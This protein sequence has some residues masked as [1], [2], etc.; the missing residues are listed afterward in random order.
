ME[1]LTNTQEVPESG[2][3]GQKIDK[4]K[5]QSK[6]PRTRQEEKVKVKNRFGRIREGPGPG[7]LLPLLSIA[8]PSG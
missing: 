6:L 4:V 2:M 8:Q 1:I 5:R 3:V 7:M